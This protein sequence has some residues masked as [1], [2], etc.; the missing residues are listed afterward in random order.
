MGLSTALNTAL[1]G[2]RVN[3]ASIEIVSRNISNVDTAGYTK[4]TADQKA[5]LLADKTSVLE[6]NAKR[7]VDQVLQKQIRTE[8]AGVGYTD[9][10]ARYLNDVDSLYG[11]PGDSFALDTL[12]N[13]FTSS[14]ETLVA[15][16][17]SFSA[18]EE[19]ISSATFFTSRLNN[20]SGDIQRLRQSAENELSLAVDSL[21]GALQRLET[22]DQDIASK[23]ASGNATADMFDVRD[24]V[25][26]EIAELIDINVTERESGGV[27]VFTTSGRVLYDGEA[28]NLSFDARGS[29]GPESAYS[30]DPSERTV[31]TVSLT[32]GSGYSVDLIANNSIRSGKIGALISL[33]DDT[34]VK[35]QQQLDEFAANFAKALSTTDVAGTAATNGAGTGFELDLANMQPGDQ[36]T[37]SYNDGTANRTLTLVRVDDAAVL[38]LDNSLTSNPNDT[39]LGLNFSDGFP[40]AADLAAL[41]VATGGTL[42][43]ASTGGTNLQILDN[44]ISLDPAPATS[45]VSAVSAS[46]TKTTVSDGDL[47]FPLFVDPTAANGVYSGEVTSSGHQK[48]G[49]SARIQL[50]SQVKNDPSLLVRYDADVG[51]GD[52]ARPLDLLARIDSAGHDFSPEAGIGSSAAPFGGNF[53]DYL[54]SH[55]AT[56]TGQA[57]IADQAKSAQDAVFSNLR[58]RF[59]EKSGVNIDEEMASLLALQNAYGANARVFQTLRELFDLLTQL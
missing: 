37:V 55:I 35:A 45:S 50:N 22:I 28:V 24:A 51:A 30:K 44:G 29:V 49:F 10:R 14:L 31:G 54:Q 20:L 53:A 27:T 42:D 4:K 17:E 19:L 3:Q 13:K 16:P 11:A 38:P 48:T 5:L 15:S 8:L 26:E 7:V 47:G 56:Q 41:G 40:D 46:F 6:L 52:S 59:G 43:F 34:L 33:R 1:S 23:F 32:T 12:Y 25:I 21:N 18:R 36:I 58:T 2:L 39:V 9:T 57:D